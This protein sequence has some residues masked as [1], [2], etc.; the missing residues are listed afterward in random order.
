VF[1]YAAARFRGA[2]VPA[3]LTAALVLL[4]AGGIVYGLAARLAAGRRVRRTEAEFRR[5]FRSGPDPMTITEL[6]TGRF[7]DVNESFER[8]FGYTRAEAVGRTSVELGFWPIAEDRARF[9]AEL[10]RAGSVRDFPLQRITRGGARVTSLISAERVTLGGVPCIIAA[11]R[12]ITA[13]EEFARRLIGAQEA[14]RRRIASEL[15]DSVG[16]HLLLVR[17]RAQ[18]VAEAEL[19]PAAAAHVAAIR[20]LAAQ[21]IAEVRQISHDLRPHQLDHLGL[22][23][24]LQA[25]CAAAAGSAEMELAYGIDEV[26]DL[27]AADDATHLY[28]I[29]QESLNNIFK[30]SAARAAWVRLE[31]SGATARL[32]VEDDGRG[33]LVPSGAG[34]AGGLGLGNIAE[35]AR[36]LG[37]VLRI[38]SAPGRGT[39]VTLTLSPPPAPL[40]DPRR[41]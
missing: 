5:A 2:P 12:N 27:F 35:R 9:L 29:V 40:P 37:G 19:P 32:T 36:I 26:D 24:A 41:A 15:H 30:H 6:R 28:R 7:L 13:R 31:R 17:N 33:F 23:R 22:T 20:D 18:L 21:A 39:V 4:G 1:G 14:E 3:G 8:F 16:Q 25:L 10:E 38:D 34:P 11:E